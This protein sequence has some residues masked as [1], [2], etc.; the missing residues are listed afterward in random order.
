MS[1][2][3]F[4]FF[5]IYPYIAVAVLLI[6]S[7]VRFDHQPY[8]WKSGSSQFLSNDGMWL[9]SN[10]FHVGI[11]LL[12]TG[13]AIGLLTPHGLYTALGLTAEAKQLLAMTAGGIFGTICFIGMT[14][15]VWRRLTDDRV[16]AAG[17]RMD[18]AILLLLY[19]QLIIGLATIPAS[20]GH[21]DAGIMLALAEWAQRIVTFRAGA[22]EQVAGTDMVFQLHLVL[23]L[24]IVLLAPFSRLVH[25]WSAP[26]S[27]LVRRYQLV[28]R[29]GQA[30][31]AI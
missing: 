1:Y 12:L 4:F 2:F 14:R 18:T 22:A 15:L 30:P 13:H 5:G 7:V 27:Y 19:V 3:N 6:G 20:A 25:V 26:L 28:R 8:T 21:H 17:S 16:R 9:S 11:I 29:R 31:E 24:T 10:A 23:G